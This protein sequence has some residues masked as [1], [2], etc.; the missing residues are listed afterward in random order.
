MVVL[1]LIA[2][3]I[4]T[5]VI[6]RTYITFL[7]F[8]LPFSIAH[9][10]TDC[11]VAKITH[12]QIENERIIYQQEGAGWRILGNVESIGKREM[13]SAMLAAQASGKSIRV[14]YQS[15]DYNCLQTS[16]NYSESAMI[17][18]TYNN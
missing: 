11:P 8:I 17:V 15:D 9:A 18:R 2:I 13:Y 7:I 4:S 1:R 3:L 10:R 5:G 16:S 6:M 12:I 14:S